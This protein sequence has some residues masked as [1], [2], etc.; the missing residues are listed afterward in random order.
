MSLDFTKKDIPSKAIRIIATQDG[1]EVGH[2]YLFLITNA[3]HTEPYGL[4]EDLKVEEAFQRNGFGPMIVEK[5]IET[6][7]AEG[8]YKLLATSRYSRDHVHR[9]YEKAGFEKQGHEFRLNL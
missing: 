8:C 2:A 9:M 7:K 4:L 3:L 1:Q 6:A 5:V